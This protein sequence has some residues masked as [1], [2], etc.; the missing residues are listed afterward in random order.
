VFI[1]ANGVIIEDKES[2][3]M[4]K[5]VQS[6]VYCLLLAGISLSIT[7]AQSKTE[8]VGCTD[9]TKYTIE[10]CINKF[11]MDKIEKTNAGYQYWFADPNLA[12]GKTLKM[13]VVAPRLATH[14]PHIHAEDEFFFVL[15]GNAE[16]YLKGKWTPAGPY[17]SFYCPSNVEHGIR[18][19]GDTELKYLVIKK[20]ESNNPVRKEFTKTQQRDK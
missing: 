16:L 1:F 13:S 17:T 19:A 2:R 7:A 4:K 12:D 9:T 11:S 20:Y 6:I 5:S 8:A 18:N 14:P 3:I 10:N 15:E